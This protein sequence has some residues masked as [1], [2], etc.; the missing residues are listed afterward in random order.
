MER[1]SLKSSIRPIL[2][3]FLVSVGVIYIGIRIYLIGH[4][5]MVKSYIAAKTGENLGFEVKIDR[6]RVGFVRIGLEGVAMEG[7][8]FRFASD[9][10]YLMPTIGSLLFFKKNMGRIYFLRPELEIESRLLRSGFSPSPVLTNLEISRVVIKEGRT[11]IKLEEKD[12]IRS[13]EFEEVNALVARSLFRPGYTISLSS[14]L[15]GSPGSEVIFHGRLH[16]S[17]QM[18]FKFENIKLKTLA[19]HLATDVRIGGELHL[20]LNTKRK[21]YAYGSM[22]LSDGKNFQKHINYYADGKIESGKT[23]INLISI[24]S[25]DMKLLLKGDVSCKDKMPYLNLKI[26]YIRF[27]LAELEDIFPSIRPCGYLGCKGRIYG[28]LDAPHLDLTFNSQEEALSLY[29]QG[30]RISLESIEGVLR[31]SRQGIDIS[32]LIFTSK[33]GKFKISEA[34]I[35]FSPFRLKLLATSEVT[36]FREDGYPFS[37]K[38]PVNLEGRLERRGSELKLEGKMASENL[39][40][41][42]PGILREPIQDRCNLTLSATLSTGIDLPTPSKGRVL[43]TSRRDPPDS[44]KGMVLDSQSQTLNLGKMTIEFGD[45]VFKSHGEIIGFEDPDIQ[46]GLS[47][48]LPLESIGLVQPRLKGAIKG[49]IIASG[50]LKRQGGRLSFDAAGRLKDVTFTIAK[51]IPE[52]TTLDENVQIDIERVDFKVLFKEGRFYISEFK[53]DL[54]GGNLKGEGDLAILE[55]YHNYRFSLE[56]NG[57]EASR[58]IKNLKEPGC[59]LSGTL[60][61]GIRL[62][63]KGSREIDGDGRVDIVKGSL[64]GLGLQETLGKMIGLPSLR[65]IDFDTLS[66]RYSLS[67]EGVDIEGFELF[68]SDVRLNGEASLNL[69]RKTFK[70][71]LCTG[72]STKLLRTSKKMRK[73]LFLVGNKTKTIEFDFKIK[74]KSGVPRIEWVPKELERKI[75]KL[76]G[77]RGVKRLESEIEEAMQNV[78]EKP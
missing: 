54:W 39:Q 76:I 72:F 78:M 57:V 48:I 9:K 59:G 4:P 22:R 66:C 52:N 34:S 17:V 10:V 47:I 8:G 3:A 38:G 64:S 73:L 56:L 49:E 65:D 67:G 35:T 15:A 11:F 46:L 77:V 5:D 16:S 45:V 63:R 28:P 18:E 55:P 75:T 2:I 33:L 12:K 30:R 25:G 21:F 60:S 44:F 61:A 36:A 32:R 23:G 14:V 37:V 68:S 6:C 27:P 42:F 19:S 51:I 13:I 58:A 7:D 70:G 26:A 53:G 29:A 1:S 50:E 41:F 43:S 62:R 71:L 20:D 69:R 24:T 40:I 74:E 31:M